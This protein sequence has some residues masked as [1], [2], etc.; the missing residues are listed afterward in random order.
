MSSCVPSDISPAAA[1]ASCVSSFTFSMA[2]AT[3]RAFVVCS[4]VAAEMLWDISVTDSL[5][6]AT[7]AMDWIWA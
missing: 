2:V 5:A 1:A 3:C 6:V 7:A 4:S